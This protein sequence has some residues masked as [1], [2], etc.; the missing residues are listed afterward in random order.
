MASEPEKAGDLPAAT[1]AEAAAPAAAAAAEASSVDD[2]A[3]MFNGFTVEE[4]EPLAGEF[5]VADWFAQLNNKMGGDLKKIQTVGR[6]MVEVWTAVGMDLERVQFLSSS[7]E[8][9]ARAGEY[10]PLVM[11]I[12]RKNNLKRI[13]RCSQIMGR[14]ETDDLS[15][16]QIFYPCM[17][18]ADIFFL[19]AGGHGVS[20]LVLP[21]L[22]GPNPWGHMLPG[23]LEGQEKMSKSDPNSAI[24]MEDEEVGAA[25]LGVYKDIDELKQD[26]LSGALHPAD[27]KPSLS[28][29]INKILQ[30]VRD[31]F[32]NNAAAKKLLAQVKVSARGRLAVTS[33][34]RVSFSV[35]ASALALCPC[36]TL[37][38]LLARPAL[39]GESYK[40]TR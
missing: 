3:G 17:Q 19:K 6:Y 8:I 24:F 4:R 13:I 30:P 9:T 27:L 36:R 28:K 37:V 16:A 23:L 33:G 26:Y 31:H 29:A 1:P 39:Y 20:S 14:T 25:A 18:C 15:A 40:V 10:W 34:Y 32:K 7:E 2:V 21:H 38:S 35:I 11:D 5:W 22:A 12:A